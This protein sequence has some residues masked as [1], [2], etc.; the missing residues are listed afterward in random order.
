MRED[1]N[2]LIDLGLLM[3]AEDSG[4]AEETV[5]ARVSGLA[6]AHAAVTPGRVRERIAELVAAGHLD[7]RARAEG[8]CLLT[9][10]TGRAHALGLLARHGARTCALVPVAAGLRMAL[11]SA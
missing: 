9:N 3:A 7:R 4:L 8:P 11:A 5:I 10:E 2:D 1:V 6:S